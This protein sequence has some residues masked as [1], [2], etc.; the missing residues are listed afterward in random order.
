MG[1]T[2]NKS[3]IGKKTSAATTVKRKAVATSAK[4]AAKRSRRVQEES[5]EEDDDD[6]S[7]KENR[8]EI[9]SA[10]EVE[11]RDEGMAEESQEVPE[12]V[13]FNFLETQQ[14][15]EMAELKARLQAKRM[16]KLKKTMHS[17]VS[18]FDDVYEAGMEE[19]RKIERSAAGQE[20]KKQKQSLKAFLESCIVE[21]DVDDSTV[22]L[23]QALKSF[24]SV[25]R[26]TGSTCSKFAGR[27]LAETAEM[28]AVSRDIIASRPKRIAQSA[29]Q[30]GDLVTEELNAMA[31]KTKVELDARTFLKEH[32][33]IMAKYGANA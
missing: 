30:I 3:S 9:E 8:E 10:E 4:I 32:F 19:M 2:K 23:E 14:K 31:E 6:M 13:E 24:K 11:D 26:E 25:A 33:K 21:P 27:D 12:A 18:Q 22:K 1:K 16:Q 15:D 7:E 20:L 28:L 5:E 17:R 29:R